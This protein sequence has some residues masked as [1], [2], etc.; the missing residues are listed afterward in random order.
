M[1]RSLLIALLLGLLPAAAIAQ[2]F[3]TRPVRLLVSYPA[4]GGVDLMARAVAAVLTQ[5]LGQQVIVDNR[6]GASGALG[7]SV[8]AKAEPD[9]YTILVTGDAPVTQVPLLSKTAYDPYRDLVALVKGVTVP[10]AILVP[11]S[12]PFRTLD[13]LLKFAAANPG[14]VTYGT[15][16]LGSAM[17]VELELLKDKLGVNITHVPYKGA[18]PIIVDTMASQITVGAPGIPVAIPNIR[19]GQ[20]RLL[21]LWSPTR[22]PVF[23][24]VPTVREATGQATLEG[25]PT[26]YGFLLPA[27]TPKAIV[28]RLERDIIASL[29]D[30]D[31]TRKLTESGAT[32]VAQPSA[33][34]DRANRVQTATFAEIFRKLDLKQE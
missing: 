29:R 9:G 8:V 2:E 22:I 24:D 4:G 33:E 34:F 21:A 30:P 26:W 14:K 19:S 10:T 1:R 18:P 31:V 11:S 20:L 25:M 27:G 5:R 6:P 3:P 17:H 28:E 12:S 7:T 16:G 23:P 13:D 32:V 15:P